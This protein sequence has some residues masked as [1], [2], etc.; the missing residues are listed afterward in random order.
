MI[1]NV[2]VASQHCNFVSQP[3]YLGRLEL[4]GHEFLGVVARDVAAQLRLDGR[5]GLALGLRQHGQHEEQPAEREQG[6]APEHDLDAPHVRYHLERVKCFW[7]KMD[8][9]MWEGKGFALLKA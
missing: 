5:E 1:P 6:E 2:R 8:L 4:D 3:K 9:I 7:M